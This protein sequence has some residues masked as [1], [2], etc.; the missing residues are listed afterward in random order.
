M[1]ALI[2]VACGVTIYWKTDNLFKFGFAMF[3]IIL[4]PSALLSIIQE[5]KRRERFTLLGTHISPQLVAE[6]PQAAVEHAFTYFEDRLRSRLGVGSEV[7][8]ENLI[9]LAYGKNG[10]LSYGDLDTEKNGVRNF[11]SGAYAAF[12][13]P[14]K[15]RMVNESRQSALEIIG[16]IETMV[17]LVEESSIQDTIDNS[18]S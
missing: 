15:H 2:L 3:F 18:I 5:D 10:K 7:F 8:G 4:L 11:L 9:N 14:R 17:R 16:L 6:N 1:F 13:N 12:R